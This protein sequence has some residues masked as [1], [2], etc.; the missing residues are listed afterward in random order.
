MYKYFSGFVFLFVFCLNLFADENKT[1]T[2]ILNYNNIQSNEGAIVIKLYDETSPKF[3]NTKSAI[4]IKTVKMENG[5]A[6]IVF[7]NLPFGVYAY[8]TFHDENSNGEM[9]TNMI[10]FPLE[11]YAFSNNLKITFGPPSFG[12]AS[13]KLDQKKM[14]I[15]VQ[16][17]Y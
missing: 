11:G 2:L 16:L 6:K 5:K 15:N 9:D 4:L 12:K 7:E 1:G 17:K 8:T 3:P 14:N 10:H 13:F